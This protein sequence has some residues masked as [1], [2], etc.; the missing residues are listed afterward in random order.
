M[1]YAMI[2]G[3]WPFTIRTSAT[4]HTTL[5]YE[6]KI[7]DPEHD[8]FRLKRALSFFVLLLQETLRPSP[9]N[10]W[11]SFCPV[12]IESLHLCPM[13][14]H[15]FARLKS[16][17]C[18]SLLLWSIM[19]IRPS[20][21]FSP[22]QWWSRSKDLVP[23]RHKEALAS[24]YGVTGWPSHPIIQPGRFMHKGDSIMAACLKGGAG[25]WRPGEIPKMIV[26]IHLKS[27]QVGSHVILLPVSSIFSSC[28]IATSTALDHLQ[29]DV[30]SL[31]PAGASFGWGSTENQ[32][33]VKARVCL[34][35]W[36]PGH[37]PH[38]CPLPVMPV[39]P[40]MPV[41]GLHTWNVH[42]I[43]GFQAV[44]QSAT[45]L[46]RFDSCFETS[47]LARQGILRNKHVTVF[48]YDKFTA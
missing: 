15:H 9:S 19:A 21:N 38:S 31:R 24:A 33:L 46:D 45:R 12:K 6:S 26:M 34:G 43:R 41:S 29:S 18:Y 3:E 1:I 44:Q 22:L 28:L 10:G 7:L 35:P 39:M 13:V 14:D 4:K 16:R 11:S 8:R 17:V 5:W 23:E 48:A 30:L 32:R 27:D 40:V 42:T 37:W 25:T 47:S 2:C 20:G 36:C